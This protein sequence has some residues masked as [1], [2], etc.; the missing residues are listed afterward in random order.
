MYTKS[1]CIECSDRAEKC[2][3]D[4]IHLPK[5]YHIIV[6]LQLQILTSTDQTQALAMTPTQTEIYRYIL[7]AKYL[8][9]YQENPYLYF[10]F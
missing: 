3:K 8:F 6:C 10:C 7:K 2:Y 5:Y 4:P 9:L 1:T